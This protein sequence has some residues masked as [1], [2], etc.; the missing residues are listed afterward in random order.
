[1][2]TRS[3][4]V[5]VV[6]ATFNGEKFLTEQ[7]RSIIGQSRLPEEI[8]ITDDGST[9]ATLDIVQRVKAD[10]PGEIA[11]R[12]V[13]QK[14][15]LGV[16]RNFAAGVAVATSNLV[17]LADQDDW[18]APD[19]LAILVTYFAT[20]PSRLL[21]H[22]DAEL[23][24]ESGRLLGMTLSDSLRMT[25]SERR[26]LIAGRALRQLVRR[27]LVTGHTVL[28]R[29]D[30]V[31]KAGEIP[32]GWLHDEWWALV[33]AGLGGAVFCPKALGHYR[34]HEVN[35][36]GATKSGL[37]RL[38]ERFSEPQSAFRARH[39]LRHEG[40]GR[41]LESTA[42]PF[43]AQATRLLQSRISHYAW[44]ATLSPSRLI[45]VL[46]ILGRVV[47]G[48]YYRYRRGMFDALRDFF[49]PGT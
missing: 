23:V 42:N 44:Q 18:W 21:V 19:K 9:D 1:M 35:Q 8:V 6:V 28:M 17:A 27:N 22:S 41:F 7:L 12:V 20:D 10:A 25:R 14:T 43:D 33:A 48:D 38:M 31:R 36:V 39:A 46:P 32:P 37:A 11:W 45:R 49:Q 29:R 24:N 34:Q 30:V 15:P 26:G 47:R 40:L 2:A 4:T 5:S 16:A 3:L 13:K